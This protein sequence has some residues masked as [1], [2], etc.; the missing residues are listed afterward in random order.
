MPALFDLPAVT[1]AAP[2]VL[3]NA[4][5]VTL[6]GG[7]EPRVPTPSVVVHGAPHRTLRRYEATRPA[8]GRPV[9]LVPPLAVAISCFDLRPSQ[10]LA[11]H[12]RDQGRVVYVV[13]YGEV[14]FSDRDMGIEDWVTD[15]VP[16]AIRRV[17]ALH[18]GAEVDVIGWSL[19][20]TVSYL[21]AA[22]D[23]DLPIA[24]LVAL[25]TP[26]DYTKVPMAAPL[27]A[28]DRLGLVGL[29]TLPVKFLG[30]VPAALVQAGYRLTAPQRE[31]TKPW[32]IARN[33]TNV[34]ALARM[35]AID[36]FQAEMPGYP[37]RFFLQ[38]MDRAMLRL[39]LRDGVIRI[40]D[41]LTVDLSRLRT[42]V[43]VVGSPVDAIA[44]APAVRAAL[45]V[46]T[47]AEE[48]RYVEVRASHLG[49]CAAPDAVDTTWAA[50]DA[51]HAVESA[52][53][54]TEDP[55]STPRSTPRRVSSPA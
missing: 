32:F 42:R 31:L 7:V 15:I 19:G 47:G 52:E 48:I 24:S 3:R 23:P 10:S 55:S 38:L 45:D 25:G 33:L 1:A 6:G 8:V 27:Q 30:G 2:T 44:P 37:G 36:R 29:A 28:L 34:P 46:L 41:D 50:I 54:R 14:D 5:A 11:A 12:L 17:S 18:E 39:E 13:D 20:G 4:W 9:L 16:T 49:L 51:F 21:T 35:E 22:H 40:H 26:I 53:D 43:L